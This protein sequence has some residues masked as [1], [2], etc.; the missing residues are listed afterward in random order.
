MFPRR[1]LLY[2][3]LYK[4]RYMRSP[5]TLT[6]QEVS[7]R[8]DILNGYLKQV[9]PFE[10]EKELSEKELAVFDPVIHT[11]SE[12]VAFCERHEFIEGSLN[13]SEEKKGGSPKPV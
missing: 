1:A 10:Q 4:R 9:P 6:A 7:V 11:L 3:R 12:S 13:N 5:R 2:Q 8:V